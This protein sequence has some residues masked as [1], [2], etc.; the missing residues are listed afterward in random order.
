MTIDDCDVQ[1]ADEL[2]AQSLLLGKEEE[3]DGEDDTRFRPFPQL[4]CNYGDVLM[5]ACVYTLAPAG[6]TAR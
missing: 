2:H 5:A 3:F 4:F 1:L 6:Y